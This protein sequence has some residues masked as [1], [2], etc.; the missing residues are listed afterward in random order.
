MADFVK[1]ATLDQLA[2]VRDDGD[3]TQRP[4]TLF[5]VKRTVHAIKDT[6]LHASVS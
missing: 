1:V 3:D 2:P 4:V 5:N 6:C